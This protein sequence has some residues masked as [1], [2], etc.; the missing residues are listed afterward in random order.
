MEEKKSYQ[1]WTISDELREVIKDEI[2]KKSETPRS[3]MFM[4][5][6]KDVNQ[7]QQERR[8]KAYFM[9]CG[10]DVSGKH[11]PGNMAVGARCTGSFKIGWQR[12]SLRKSGPRDWNSMM[13]WR[14]SAG[15][16]K[17]WM[18]VW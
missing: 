14:G 12:D 6:G 9:C 1:S 13:N 7:C 5:Q 2:P 8:W 10:R 18:A 3:I 4:R 11:C 15:S 16:G 17:V